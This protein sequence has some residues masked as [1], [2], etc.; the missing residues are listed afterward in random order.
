MIIYFCNGSGYLQRVCM[1]KRFLSVI[2]LMQICVCS[3]YAE[4]IV[5]INMDEAIKIAI[6]KNITYQSKKK[7][8]EIAEKNIKIANRLKNPQFFSHTLI[9]RV[10][11]SNNSQ[12]GM[13]IPV[14]VMKRGARKKVAIA[15][16]EKAKTELERYEYNLRVDVM[17]A[18]F[19]ILIAKSYYI[20]MQR[21]ERWYKAV[22]A[23]AEHKK[24]TEPR[25]EINVLRAKTKH[26]RELMDLN[27]LQSNVNSAI[28]NFNKV[29]NTNERTITYDTVENSL[30]DNKALMDIEIP[31]YEHLEEVALKHNYELKI[32][33]DDIEIAGRN[34]TLA[35]RQ[36]I[37]DLQLAAGYA[38]QKMTVH[39]P[40]NGAYVTAGVDLPIFYT[41]RP[42]IQKA[43]IML[44]RVK[45]DKVAYEDILRYTIQ[46]NYNKF[47]A[48]KKNMEC[49]KKIYD[50]MDRILILES[51]A[52]ERNEIRLMDLMA[53]EDS[54]QQY[55]TEFINSINLYYKAY[56]DLLRNLG[57]DITEVL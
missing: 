45:C 17:D 7:E 32:S 4:D 14:E 43:K 56:L 48:H 53:I 36:V 37:P 12:L 51:R 50:D 15:E 20:L 25:Y 9:G 2:I 38:Y 52:Y 22:L 57:H 47:Y 40:Y 30:H 11:R 49:A 24:N 33:K 27:Y 16:Y 46:D 34:V 41:Y 39:D 5:K 18:Y 44:D 42:E 23:V 21:K 10:T 3:V 13:N 29:L 28:C 35:K 1:V 19:D 8:L 26:E 6:A 54:Q 31:A 55:M